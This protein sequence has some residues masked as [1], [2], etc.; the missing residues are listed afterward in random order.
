MGNIIDDVMGHI[1]PIDKKEVDEFK[2]LVSEEAFLTEN[3]DK[4][5]FS[6]GFPPEL[7]GAISGLGAG[8]VGVGVVFAVFAGMSGAE[9]MAAL[10]GFGVVHR[11]G[12]RATPTTGVGASP[13]STLSTAGL[14]LSL[15]PPM[16]AVASGTRRVQWQALDAKAYRDVC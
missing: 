14:Q 15:D 2:L 4:I 12:Y 3:R 11:Q 13:E 16:S 9:I 1:T 7:A 8:A 5:T 6:E 10:A